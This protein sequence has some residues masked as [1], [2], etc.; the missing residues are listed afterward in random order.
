MEWKSCIS[1]F[2]ELRPLV[3]LLLPLSVH[4]V[5]EQMTV[6]VLVDVVTAA[7][8]PGQSTC[9]QAIY[10]SGL[11]QVV[12]GIFKMVVL[13]LLGQ[14]ADEY[15]RKP[16]LLLTVST[17]IFP[18]ALLAYDQSRGFVYAYYVLRTISYILS[19][20]SI[21]CI[22]VAYAADF[23]QE[24]K[25]A[26]VF[27]WM[28]G[29]FSASHVLGNILARFLPE[30]YIFLVSIA[31]LIFGP[32]Y[33]QFFLVETVERAQRKD[34]NSTFLTKI[35]KVFHTRYKSMRDAAIIVFSSP[36]LRGI[37]FVSFFY[38]LGMSGI[39]AVLLF[40]LKSVF[41][42]NKNQYSEILL[43]VGIGEI[44]SQVPYLSAS[45]GAIF[46]LVTPSTYAIIS[47]ASSSMN[48]GKA[49]GF[50][51]GVQSIA[52]LLSP[53]AM[54]PLTSWF[55]S[56]NAPFD[57]K[58]FSIIVASLCMMVAFCYACM[59]KPEQETKNLEEDIEAPLITDN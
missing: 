56:S 27:S 51:A 17:S 23:V 46:V 45:F 52:S 54:S 28:T 47:K 33:M 29:L 30:K 59:L 55:L 9:A 49:Q 48:Q 35:I 10:I 34:Q 31:L 7:L 21:F 19:Q 37:S 25:R 26:A 24:D 15:G 8:C 3:H 22:S 44:F 32:I 58:G 6:S 12:V 2:R 5:A 36:T 57:C 40:Y 1:G 4:W 50:V 53:L 20:G 14:L 38:E 42:F 43:M 39:N 16:F 13:P 11:Q 41:G 18:F